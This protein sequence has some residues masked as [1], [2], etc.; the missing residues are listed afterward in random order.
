MWCVHHVLE[1]LILMTMKWSSWHSVQISL[2]TYN[3]L[4]YWQEYER[5]CCKCCKSRLSSNIVKR[6]LAARNA[7]RRR[8]VQFWKRD[9]LVKSSTVSPIQRF[10][11]ASQMKFV[12]YLRRRKKTKNGRVLTFMQT[13]SHSLPTYT[14]KGLRE[15]CLVTLVRMTSASSCEML[16]AHTN[17]STSSIHS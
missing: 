9:C 4:S 3:N 1:D 2:D 11:Q 5:C 7:S 14:K 6:E 17:V 13:W 15:S 12:E 16:Q 8:T 10:A